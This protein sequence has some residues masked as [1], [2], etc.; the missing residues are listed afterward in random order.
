MYPAGGIR[1]ALVGT[2]CLAASLA[3]ASTAWGDIFYV[4]PTGDNTGA[5]T[6]PGAVACQ[7]IVGALAKTRATAGGDTINV[8]AGTYDERLTLDQ[9]S[10]DGTNIVGAGPA[11]TIVR[12][13]NGSGNFQGIDIGSPSQ[14]PS[15]QLSDLKIEQDAAAGALDVWTTNGVLSNVA[16]TLG[17]SGTSDTAVAVTVGHMT[18]DHVTMS[19]AWTGGGVSGV[20]PNVAIDMNDSVITTNSNGIPLTVSSTAP[21]VATLH[22]KRSVLHAAPSSG[23]WVI[24]TQ[25][26]DATID[27][28]LLTGATTGLLAGAVSEDR[29]ATLRNDTIDAGSPGVADASDHGVWADSGSAGD[30][31]SIGVDSSI[32]LEQ[33]KVDNA[34]TVTCTNSDVQNQATS[35]IACG[36]TGPN[37]SSTPAD[38][39]V[40]ASGGDYHLKPSPPSPAIDTGSSAALAGD[41]STTDLDGNPRVTDGNFDC[42]ARRDRGAYEAPAPA[43]SISAPD[44]APFGSPVAFSG[45]ISVETADLLAFDWTFSDGGTASSQ[46]ASH[47]FT[48]SGAQQAML[49]VTDP[50]GCS[51]TATHDIAIGAKPAPPAGPPPTS[52]PAGHV[53]FKLGG[54]KKQKLGRFIAVTVVCPTQSCAAAVTGSLNVPGAAKRFKLTKVTRSLARGRK[55]TLKLALSKAGRKAAAHALRKHKKVGARIT[56]RVTGAAGPATSRVA[57]HL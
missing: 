40:D 36:P 26:A 45:Q 21:D 1:A 6:A 27:S 44:S 19:G 50:H 38:L 32:V 14:S 5:C 48:A 57:L 11:Q 3:L 18:F 41:E 37:S 10:D 33:Q 39:F 35:A 47:A 24:G 8:A 7:T 49:K 13:Q 43:A 23:V 31:M 2:A 42:V 4:D 34:N 52:P 51:V 29:T 30:V 20:G 53:A 17:N 46:N 55:T 15:V 22:L 9:A 12:H 56:V 28:S 16:I 54:S 25:N